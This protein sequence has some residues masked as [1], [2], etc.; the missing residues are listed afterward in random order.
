MKKSKARITGL[1]PTKIEDVGMEIIV[2]N[3]SVALGL[4]F[5]NNVFVSVK[6]FV[7]VCACSLNLFLFD[8]LLA[9][10]TI[11]DSTPYICQSF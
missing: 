8:I 9:D 4:F 10:E 5:Y 3:N 2:R 11:L 1:K 6:L 7:V